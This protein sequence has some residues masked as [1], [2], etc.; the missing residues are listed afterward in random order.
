VDDLAV[1]VVYKASVFGSFPVFSESLHDSQHKALLLIRESAV[2]THRVEAN[3]EF[4]FLSD[5]GSIFD[6]RPLTL[7]SI[8]RLTCRFGSIFL[9]YLLVL[10]DINLPLQLLLSGR[11]VLKIGSCGLQCLIT[12]A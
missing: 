12:E 1:T 8:E 6:I 4:L 7:F 9:L 3:N 5:E 2:L 11:Y 10:I